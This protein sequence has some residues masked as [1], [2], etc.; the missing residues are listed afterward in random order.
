MTLSISRRNFVGLT[1]A[2]V[3][4]AAFDPLGI[5][6]GRTA[7]A[8][9]PTGEY[10]RDF[11]DQQYWFGK[12]RSELF[13]DSANGALYQSTKGQLSFRL[14]QTG[15]F[16]IAYFSTLGFL[17]SYRATAP[18][19]FHDLVVNAARIP[20]GPRRIAL[21]LDLLAQHRVAARLPQVTQ[22]VTW[23]VDKHKG[24]GC[25]RMRQ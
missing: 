14:G 20:A 22:P 6:F 18:D 21:T 13:S 19:D 3:A 23:A 2:T 10:L 9:I 1:A 7:R 24:D 5:F 11:S 16:A 4:G 25:L 15:G 8:S 17:S 12:L